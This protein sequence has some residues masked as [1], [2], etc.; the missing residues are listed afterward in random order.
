MSHFAAVWTLSK[1]HVETL[2][3]RRQSS[4]PLQEKTM[5]NSAQLTF[6]EIHKRFD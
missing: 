4:Q 5:N 1:H 6:H 3:T 2:P